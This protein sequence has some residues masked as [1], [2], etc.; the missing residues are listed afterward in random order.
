MQISVIIPTFNEEKNIGSLVQNLQANSNS[1]HVEIIVV[2]GQSYDNTKEI[3]TRNGATVY[4]CNIKSRAAQMNI[5]ALQ[6][7]GDI[8]YFVHADAMPP[9]TY[10]ND[11]KEAIIQQKKAGC[12]RLKF[13]TSSKLLKINEFFTRFKGGYYGGGDQTLYIE[14]NAFKDLDGF[15]ERYVIMEDF[16]FTKRI[17]KRCG[18][19]LIQKDVLVS[20]RKYE[21]N[22]Y[23]KVNFA[24]LIMLTLFKLNMEPLKLKLLYKKLL[25]SEDKNIKT[26]A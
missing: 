4:T 14:K 22:N 7:K 9:A 6:A 2:D 3:A 24:N 20:A 13:N 23:F 25:V 1:Q 10:Y 11:I 16:E 21:L 5:G 12:F 26:T 17:K 8:F 19:H 15:N 18:L